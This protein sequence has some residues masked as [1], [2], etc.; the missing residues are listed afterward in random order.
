MSAWLLCVIKTNSVK[1]SKAISKLSSDA[2][3]GL[4]RVADIF[5]IVW[6]QARTTLGAWFTFD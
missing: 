6:G 4:A 3:P 5:D 2:L 1:S